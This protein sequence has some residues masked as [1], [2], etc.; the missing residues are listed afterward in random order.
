MDLSWTF[1]FTGW[2]YADVDCTVEL[3][4]VAFWSCGDEEVACSLVVDVIWTW[5]LA[6]V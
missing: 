3:D 5:E 4:L 1:S 2:E 6:W